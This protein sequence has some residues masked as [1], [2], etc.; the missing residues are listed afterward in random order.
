MKYTFILDKFKKL[1]RYHFLL[2]IIL[3]MAMIMSFFVIL[4]VSIEQIPP[5]VYCKTTTGEFMKCDIKSVCIMPATEWYIDYTN[6][7]DNWK[8]RYNL[9]CDREVYFYYLTSLIFACDM[10]SILIMS[11][12]ADKVGRKFIF[13]LEVVGSLIS[14]IILYIEPNLASIFIGI[15]VIDIFKHL[16]S[17]CLLYLYEYFPTNYYY[18]IVSIHNVLY[19]ILG[20]SISYYAEYYKETKFLVLLMIIISTIVTIFDLFLLTES[21]DWLLNNIERYKWDDKEEYLK[22]LTSDYKFLCKFNGE[23]VNERLEEFEAD[24]RKIEVLTH[25]HEGNQKATKSFTKF[26]LEN[27]KEKTYLKHFLLSLYLWILNQVTFYLSLTNLYKFNTYFEDAYQ[28]FFIAHITSN[29]LVGSLTQ[30]VGLYNTVTYVSM[31]TSIFLIAMVLIVSDAVHSGPMFNRFVFFMF[32]LL[33]SFVGESIYLYIPQ[34]FP[35]NIRSTSSSYS[36]IPAKL[37]L[38]LCPL[39]IG[40]SMLTMLLMFTALAGFAPLVVYL[41]L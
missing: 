29:V 21:P 25:N 4:V 12:I 11:I 33:S 26:L 39:I 8:L 28:I 32:S 17:T 22:R 15:F 41:C 5:L 7:V 18:I 2:A 19:G 40:G 35:P 3:N 14:Y 34:L 36:K 30:K 13:R 27:L 23:K 16:L 31:L 6:S 9:I 37:L 10:L 38:V 1:G 24:L 20:L